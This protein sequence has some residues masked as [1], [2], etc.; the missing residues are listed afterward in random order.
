MVHFP[1]TF[2][3]LTLKFLVITKFRESFQFVVCIY[4]KLILWFMLMYANQVKQVNKDPIGL[5]GWTLTLS[6]NG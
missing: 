3:A 1:K 5:I 4:L 2:Q 6:L